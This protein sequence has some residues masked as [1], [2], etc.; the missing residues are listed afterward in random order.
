MERHTNVLS[1]GRLASLQ[2]ELRSQTEGKA[3]C[4]TTSL[5]HSKTPEYRWTIPLLKI[6][7]ICPD[8]APKLSQI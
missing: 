4:F 2:C 3:L 8:L 7:Y 1:I 5:L 6:E